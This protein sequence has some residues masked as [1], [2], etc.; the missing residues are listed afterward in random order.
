VNK[1]FAFGVI[2]AVF[3]PAVSLAQTVE[4]QNNLYYGIT[5]SNDVSALQEFLT[6]QGVY[7]GPVSGNFFSLTLAGVK[8]FQRAEGVNPLSGFF[9]P[10][11]RAVA[12]TILADQIG[13]NSEGNATSTQTPVDLSQQTSQ[14]TTTYTPTYVNNVCPTGY[15]GTYPDCVA[16]QCPQF[17]T[18]TYPNC[19]PPLCPSGTTGI[20][21]NCQSVS[22]NNGYLCPSGYSGTYPNCVAPPCPSGYT[23]AY[24]NC[25]AP[26]QTTTQCPAGDTGTYPNCTTTVVTQAPAPNC[27]ISAS[28]T[29]ILAGQSATLTWSSNNAQS[30]SISGIGPNL[31]LSG[32]QSVTPSQTTTY[33]GNF[34]TQSGQ[35]ASCHATITITQPLTWY[36]FASQSEVGAGLISDQEGNYNAQNI[37]AVWIS[38]GN[39]GGA[40]LFAGYSGNGFKIASIPALPQM[41]LTFQMKTNGLTNATIPTFIANNWNFNISYN[42]GVFGVGVPSGSLTTKPTNVDQNYHTYAVTYDGTNVTLYMDGQVIG[43]ATAANTGATATGEWDFGMINNADSTNNSLY[44]TNQVTL[45]DLQIY[46]QVLTSTQIQSLH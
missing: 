23:G 46:S 6:D 35:T 45:D 40:V 33:T 38:N 2:L 15:S 17:N 8:A 37:N 42:N 24:P 44:T 5:G 3:I 30:G 16:L 22:N 27:T 26:T 14:A 28:P 21:P 10:I 39:D 11:T 13:S 32:S 29:A 34:S 19:V 36:N 43:F 41:T 25:A 18:G 9:G 31:D 20:Y 1:H 7:H 12:N 4:F